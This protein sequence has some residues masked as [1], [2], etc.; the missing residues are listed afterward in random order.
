[1]LPGG[2]L[3]GV[4]TSLASNTI[5]FQPGIYRIFGAMSNFAIDR[6]LPRLQDT[7]NGV[8]IVTGL[9]TWPHVQT[10]IGGILNTTTA[11]NVQLQ[12]WVQTTSSS[13]QGITFLGTGTN[14]YALLEIMRLNM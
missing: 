7:T 9:S 4:Y 11:V 14:T 13:G 12:Q 2:N 10:T 1:M 8:T 5:T 6:N 3:N